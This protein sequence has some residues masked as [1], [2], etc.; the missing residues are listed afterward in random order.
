MIFKTINNHKFI[1]E[2]YENI[3]LYFST[4]EGELNFNKNSLEGIEN[5]DKLK[6]WFNVNEVGYLNQIHSDL[7]YNYDGQIHQGDALITNNKGVAIGVFTADCVPVLI[8]DKKKKVIAAVHSG[9]KGT[10]N[11]IVS[12]TIDKMIQEYGSKIENI[13]IYIGPHISKCCYEIGNDVKEKF[14]LNDLY[15]R[16]VINDNKLDLTKCIDKQLRM[17]N[18]LQKNIHIIKNCTFCDINNNWFSYRKNKSKKRM[19]SFIAIK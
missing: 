1:G 4:G 17:K 14:E 5:L 9:W 11:L 7:I 10:F 13:V 6:Q 2:E 19:F 12:K 8:F 15:G 16:E 18:I 3:K